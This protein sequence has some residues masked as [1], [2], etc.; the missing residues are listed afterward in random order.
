MT[1]DISVDTTDIEA[2]AIHGFL[3]GDDRVSTSRIT[4]GL[5]AGSGFIQKA[6]YGNE[7]KTLNITSNLAW[8]VAG[9]TA[10]LIIGKRAIEQDFL[11]N[12]PHRSGNPRFLL[13]RQ[14]RRT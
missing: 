8:D 11:L 1:Y 3:D 9:G 12:F 4:S 5:P 6:P 7:V 14:Q 10:N 13:D 2:T